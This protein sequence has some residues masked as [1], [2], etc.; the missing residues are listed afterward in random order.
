M[1]AK[2][3][4]YIVKSEYGNRLVRAQNKAA[5]LRH[6]ARTSLTVAL[7]TQ[8]DIID[9]ISRQIAVEDAIDDEQADLVFGSATGGD[10]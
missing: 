6:A 1:T 3:R 2:T 5:A 10:A 9:A 8:D 7:A 4:V